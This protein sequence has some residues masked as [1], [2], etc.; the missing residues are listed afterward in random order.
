MENRCVLGPVGSPKV[1]LVQSHDSVSGQTTVGCGFDHRG[2]GRT[3]VG[4]RRTTVDCGRPV[5]GCGQTRAADHRG[6]WA[7]HRGLWAD[8]P[9]R[10]VGREPFLF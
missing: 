1:A 7:D 3:L 6:L 4:C 10:A 8:G 9:P 5:V 2:S